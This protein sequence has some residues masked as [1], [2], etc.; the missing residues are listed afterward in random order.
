M[1]DSNLKRCAWVTDDPL[2]IGY[3]DLEW[4]VP[5][6]DDTALFE[7]MVL[8]LSQSGLSWLTIL[9]K[10]QNYRAAFA[11][12][13]PEKVAR[14]GPDMVEALMMDSGIVRN[15]KKIEAAVNNAKRVL[16]VRMEHGSF[17]DYLWSFTGKAPLVNSFEHISE[18]PASTPESVAMSRDLKRRGFSFMGP[19]V[20]YAFMQAVGM[21]N[22][23]TTDCFRHRPLA[24][25]SR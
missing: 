16:E 15:R 12:F 14:F 23:H 18:V 9:R 3:H 2:Y 4:G 13:D 6:Y 5:N 19:V 1:S 10:R 17:S 7:F 20:C 24:E 11:G 22:D 8:E 21:V 25:K